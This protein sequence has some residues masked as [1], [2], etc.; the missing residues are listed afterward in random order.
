MK[1]ELLRYSAGALEKRDWCGRIEYHVDGVPRFGLTEN[2]G[3]CPEDYLF[4][5]SLRDCLDIGK[6]MQE[7]HEAGRKGEDFTLTTI[8][9]ESFDD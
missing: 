8:E 3:D 2:N 4:K 6:L 1:V 7:A 5:R 9:V